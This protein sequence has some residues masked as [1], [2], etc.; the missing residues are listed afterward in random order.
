MRFDE[1]LPRGLSLPVWS[2]FN[3]VLF[4]DIANSRIGY[5]VADVRESALDTI[6]AP[7][8]ILLGKAKDQIDNHLADSWTA[9]LPPARV[10]PLL[11][12]Q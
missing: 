6:E 3:S 11:G 10:I 1:G 4:E 5:V 9:R 12:N 7:V 2:R 8:W